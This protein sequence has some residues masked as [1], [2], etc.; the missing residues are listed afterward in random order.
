M[1]SV[2]IL[3]LLNK[4]HMLADLVAEVV[5]DIPEISRYIIA[6]TYGYT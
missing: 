2:K 3:F 4:L 6:V 5:K 1:W